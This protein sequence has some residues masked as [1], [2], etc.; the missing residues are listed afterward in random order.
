LINGTLPIHELASVAV[1]ARGI[2]LD[3]R[4]CHFRGGAFVDGRSD[5]RDSAQMVRYNIEK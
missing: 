3:K 4:S 1:K 5:D 2:F